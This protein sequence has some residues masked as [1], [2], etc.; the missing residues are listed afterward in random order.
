M[1]RL[2]TDNLWLKVQYATSR[3]R[4]AHLSHKISFVNGENP[5]SLSLTI[6][7]HAHHIANLDNIF[8]QF[9]GQT[10]DIIY[11]IESLKVSLSDASLPFIQPR[12]TF[13]QYSASFTRMCRNMHALLKPEGKVSRG[14]ILISAAF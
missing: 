6:D 5:L 13:T 12:F 2:Y 7:V 4:E 9:S 3:V 14:V 8:E 1:L 11:A 10:F